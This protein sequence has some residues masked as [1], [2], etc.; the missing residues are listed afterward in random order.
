MELIPKMGED[1]LHDAVVAVVS[2]LRFSTFFR[3]AWH[4][5]HED[6][7]LRWGWHIDCI[8]DHAE[9]LINGEFVGLDI[10]VPPGF[11]KSL[12]CSVMFPAW[13][14]LK[15]PWYKFLASST[16]D[17][18]TLR[19]ARR[20]R[21]LVECDWYRRIFRPSW[22]LS[23]NQ[24]ADGN[25]ATTRGGWRTSRTVRSSIIGSRPNGRL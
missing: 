15:R 2:E 24:A 18:V 21:Q 5:F 3:H 1:E 16:N 23:K 13:V 14:W 12:T 17:H 9:A 20:H 11:V 25:F 6:E 22:T 8:C 7:P 10:N 19:D 4:V